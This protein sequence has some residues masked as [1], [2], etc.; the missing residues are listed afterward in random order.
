MR[1]SLRQNLN[2]CRPRFLL[3]FA[4]FLMVSCHRSAA[5][6]DCNFQDWQNPSIVVG[7]DHVNIVLFDDR[8]TVTMD[9]LRDYLSQV[10]NRY[11]RQGRIVRIN[12][13][14]LRAPNADDLIRRNMQQTKQI[15]HSLGI[16]IKCPN[17][18]V[19][20]AWPPNKSLHASRGSVFRMKL[21]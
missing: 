12:E 6:L 14:G 13:G 21:S 2:W 9:K 10:P 11:W 1:R 3:L 15:V 20:G 5:K 7:A 16:Q 4:A 18:G 17:A 19:V 8:A